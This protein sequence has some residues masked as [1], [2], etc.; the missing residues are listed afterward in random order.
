MASWWR[1]GGGQRTFRSPEQFILEKDADVVTKDVVMVA[2][3]G[4]TY[5]LQKMARDQTDRMQSS[6]SSQSHN[7]MYEFA[8]RRYAEMADEM[9]ADVEMAGVALP[10]RNV[11]SQMLPDEDGTF[12]QA[13]GPHAGLEGFGILH[14]FAVSRDM[15]RFANLGGKSIPL[16]FGEAKT[17][18]DDDGDGEGGG[19]AGGDADLNLLS[20]WGQCTPAALLLREMRRGNDENRFVYSVAER[21]ERLNNHHRGEA[22]R[23]S[24]LSN[25]DSVVVKD[26]LVE[27]LQLLVA[28][29][30][31][32]S[33]SKRV[34]RQMLR[35]LF[36]AFWMT[37]YSTGVTTQ[38]RAGN[39]CGGGGDIEREANDAERE[40]RA[41]FQAA[42][43]LLQQ[44]LAM[45]D[46]VKVA[47][48]EGRAAGLEGKVIAGNTDNNNN[49]DDYDDCDDDEDGSGARWPVRL[50]VQTLDCDLAGNPLAGTLQRLRSLSSTWS[51]P[52]FPPASAVPATHYQGA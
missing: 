48:E 24:S 50:L 12:G 10:G 46:E 19:G 3:L 23:R 47:E 27:C 1:G 38:I 29:V 42:H 49:D 45:D 34:R 25:S 17:G 31:E 11:F 36:E 33:S 6:Y 41:P 16:L 52:P 7:L 40:L 4:I 21:H 44:C 28:A 2:R 30:H 14:V 15:V 39:R 20:P 26:G 9:V 37:V 35:E 13:H 43:Q 22:T 8:D 18:S 5:Q 32:R 51:W